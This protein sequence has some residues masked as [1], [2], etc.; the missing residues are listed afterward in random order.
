MVG[1]G[2][3]AQAGLAQLRG[4]VDVGAVPLRS[5]PAVSAAA[6]VGGGGKDARSVDGD[7]GS[8]RKS[9]GGRQLGV[10][11][12]DEDERTVVESQGD[13]DWRQMLA[14]YER[15]QQQQQHLGPREQEERQRLLEGEEIDNLWFR[16]FLRQPLQTQGPTTASAATHATG[17]GSGTGTGA[18]A[19]TGMRKASMCTHINQY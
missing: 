19:G 8:H 4:E 14:N 12:E 2:W 15:R 1:G 3:R 13:A 16:G 18:G 7:I 9:K 6:R 17:T 5:T 10:P 11:A